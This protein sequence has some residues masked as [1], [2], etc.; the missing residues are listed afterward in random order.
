M[1]VVCVV[2]IGFMVLM[3]G[4]VVVLSSVVL[5]ASDDVKADVN[6]I[7]KYMQTDNKMMIK[8]RS[9]TMIHDIAFFDKLHTSFGKVYSII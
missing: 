6:S 8:T 5:G 4:C 9:I 2:S 1:V 7:S 3:I